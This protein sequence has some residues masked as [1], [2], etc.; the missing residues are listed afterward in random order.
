MEPG[1]SYYPEISAG[2]HRFS[3]RFMVNEDPSKR[4]EQYKEDVSFK[5]RMC[6]I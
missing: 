6:T 3:I 4:A 1:S 5:L 2:K